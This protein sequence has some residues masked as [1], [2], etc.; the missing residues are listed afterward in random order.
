MLR[1]GVV[2]LA[3]STC[4]LHDP[5][6]NEDLMRERE[7]E[8]GRG[9]ETEHRVRHTPGSFPPRVVFE[10]HGWHSAGRRGMFR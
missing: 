9:R 6:W 3:L 1:A 4:F 5:G 7:E 2:R 8:R 10:H